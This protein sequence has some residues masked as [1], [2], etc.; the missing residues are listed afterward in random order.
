[1][2]TILFP[3]RG[4]AASYRHGAIFTRPHLAFRL[5]GRSLY[6]IQSWMPETI[7]AI[8]GK[9]QIASTSIQNLLILTTSDSLTLDL[10]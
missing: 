5:S 2:T 1:M 6:V 9:S 7:E 10:P 8:L 3:T 4:G